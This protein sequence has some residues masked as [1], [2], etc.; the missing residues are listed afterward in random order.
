[1]GAKIKE[2]YADIRHLQDVKEETN[3]REDAEK[4]ERVAAKVDAQQCLENEK[5]LSNDLQKLKVSL[6]QK[7]ISI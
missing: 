2:V 6:K 3:V 7:Q 5:V 4:R 1:M